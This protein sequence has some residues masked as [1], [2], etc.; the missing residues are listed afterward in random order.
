MDRFTIT[1]K[2]GEL[3]REYVVRNL[4]TC[5]SYDPYPGRMCARK[6]GLAHKDVT[7]FKATAKVKENKKTGR[8]EVTDLNTNRSRD[9]LWFY[10]LLSVTTPL[11]RIAQDIGRDNN[12]EALFHVPQ[13][14]KGFV[15]IRE[16]HAQIQQEVLVNDRCETTR[17]EIVRLGNNVPSWL[18]TLCEEYVLESFTKSLEEGHFIVA[19]SLISMESQ[20]NDNVKLC[21]SVMTKLSINALHMKQT[22]YTVRVLEKHVGSWSNRVASNETDEQKLAG[23]KETRRRANCN[24]F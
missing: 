17:K 19:F 8:P 16:T 7:D 23:E 20:V 18:M 4:Y 13:L 15:N 10:A 22:E 14:A 24:P 11:E 1:S 6:V 3:P 12:K 2:E 21:L 9:E 5:P